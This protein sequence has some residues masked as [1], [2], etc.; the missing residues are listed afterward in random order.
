MLM[1]D[2]YMYYFVDQNQAF[3]MGYKD[4]GYMH[5]LFGDLVLFSSDEDY[6]TRLRGLLHSMF[7]PEM[8]DRFLVTVHRTCDLRLPSL[9]QDEP[10][11]VYDQFKRL[12]TEMC[13]SLFLGMDFKSSEEEAKK[14]VALTVSHW[15]GKWKM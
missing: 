3:E 12:T 4:F 1:Q 9:V 6:V 15:H 2:T 13:L 5:S 11:A 14:I 8:V 10:V 7:H